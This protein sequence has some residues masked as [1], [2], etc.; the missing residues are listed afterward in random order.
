[1]NIVSANAPSTGFASGPAPSGI[2]ADKTGTHLYVTDQ[3]LNQVATYTLTGGVPALAG[4]TPTDAQPMGMSFDLTGKYLYVAAYTANAVD[5]YTVGANGVPVR[6]AASASV[7]TGN[8]PTCVTVSGAPSN[9]NPTHAE[10]LYTSNQLSSNLTGEQVNQ[11]DGSL[12]QIQGTP[13]AGSAL[14][15][16][17]VTVPAFPIR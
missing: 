7:Q 15:T 1:M 14:P 12:D 13:F 3:T 2:L 5:T 4:T 10:Y 6:A 9:A 8:G 11:A 16:C 17:A